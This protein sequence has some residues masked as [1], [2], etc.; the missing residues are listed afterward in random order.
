LLRVLENN[1]LIQE[2]TPK[3]V[4][5]PRALD[6][7]FAETWGKYISVVP[8]VTARGKSR[9]SGDQGRIPKVNLDLPKVSRDFPLQVV[10]QRAD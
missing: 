7:L 8:A 3:A 1:W 10:F 6:G 2:I 4:F 9:D 5:L